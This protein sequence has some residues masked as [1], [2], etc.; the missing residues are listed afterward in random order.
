MD[1]RAQLQ[2]LAHRLHHEDDEAAKQLGADVQRS[3]DED[4]HH[5]LGERLTESAVEFETSHP[6][7]SSFLLRVADALAASGL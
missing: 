7:L 3:L 5:G 6:D 2:E 1:L 4:D